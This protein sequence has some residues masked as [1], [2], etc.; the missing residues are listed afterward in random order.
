MPTTTDYSDEVRY[1]INEAQHESLVYRNVAI[2]KLMNLNTAESAHALRLVL[3]NIHSL[4]VFR[5]VVPYLEAMA[6]LEPL[7]YLRDMLLRPMGRR[8]HNPHLIALETL[9]NYRE[10]PET[11][12]IL[13]EFL[14]TLPQHTHGRNRTTAAVLL[15]SVGTEDA[16]YTLAQVLVNHTDLPARRSAINGLVKSRSPRVPQ[17][18][19]RI[20]DDL[21]ERS[22]PLAT[23]TNGIISDMASGIHQLLRCGIMPDDTTYTAEVFVRWLYL[24][25]Y[26]MTGHVRR[27]LEALNT[28][29]AQQALENWQTWRKTLAADKGVDD[30]TIFR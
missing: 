30:V 16:L 6:V 15:G 22:L 27:V 24:L 25:P 19:L 13:A 11:A 20:M 28:T 4:V 5:M 10:H 29:A 14:F 12:G 23:E 9:R 2:K 8:G 17:M 26:G 18:L 3:D 21:L 7:P 1:L